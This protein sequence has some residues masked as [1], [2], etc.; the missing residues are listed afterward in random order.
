MRVVLA[1]PDG[2]QREVL[3]AG[4]PRQGEHIRPTNGPGTTTL[5]VVGVLWTEGRESPPE[6]LVIVSVRPRDPA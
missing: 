6:P 2:D 3:L 4:V 5:L 1:Y